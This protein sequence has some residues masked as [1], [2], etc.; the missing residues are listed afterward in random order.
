MTL[1]TPVSTPAMQ[2]GPFQPPPR[3]ARP[4]A[5]AGV[6]AAG[7]AAGAVSTPANQLQHNH[8]H[9]HN[10]SNS[11]GSSFHLDNGSPGRNAQPYSSLSDSTAIS[12]LSISAAS[13]SGL[14]GSLAGFS[15]FG[16]PI[17]PPG[18]QQQQQAQE[19]ARTT[20]M[21]T[22]V[23]PSG[24]IFR[25]PAQAAMFAGSQSE[26]SL[27]SASAGTGTGAESS[28]SASLSF[29]NRPGGRATAHAH[30]PWPGL[31]AP[32]SQARTHSIPMLSS[33][34]PALAQG[35]ASTTA[36]S[37]QST[38]QPDH[39]HSTGALVGSSSRTQLPHSQ[40]DVGDETQHSLY[41]AHSTS[42]DMMMMARHIQ[43]QQHPDSYD[44][45]DEHMEVEKENRAQMD[46]QRRQQ[47]QQQQSNARTR[48]LRLKAHIQLGL[49]I[50]IAKAPGLDPLVN[51]IPISNAHPTHARTQTGGKSGT[52]G[53]A[54]LLPL[55]LP[56]PAETAS[57][58]DRA[59]LA[60]RRTQTRETLVRSHVLLELDNIALEHDRQRLRLAI[61]EK[62]K[63][64]RAN[65]EEGRRRR[66]SLAGK[67]EV[68]VE[69]EVK[70]ECKKENESGNAMGVV[71][72]SSW[73]TVDGGARQEASG[74]PPRFGPSALTSNQ[75]NE[76][77]TLLRASPGP[78]GKAGGS[79]PH[80]N[81]VA[82]LNNENRHA[83]F[84]LQQQVANAEPFLSDW[85]YAPP[86]PGSYSST[87]SS[88]RRTRLT[89]APPLAKQHLQQHALDE[90]GDDGN[91][92]LSSSSSSPALLL[93]L[94][95]SNRSNGSGDGA[96]GGFF[97]ARQ[98]GAELGS[99]APAWD[100]GPCGRRLRTA[101]ELEEWGWW[102]AAGLE[103]VPGGNVT[104]LR[105]AGRTRWG[106]R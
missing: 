1:Q 75:R 47:Q 90:E 13:S 46:Q 43:R 37:Q 91:A 18:A 50:P 4:T 16:R 104:G 14:D 62:S 79:Q 35:V 5:A 92:D 88:A 71:P 40:H 28:F 45:I 86:A 52:Q 9:T 44:V 54:S 39:A 42:T 73:S 101:G 66:G 82:M 84:L 98:P 69:V 25:L 106:R 55:P 95:A 17:P 72:S 41:Q 103:S 65:R 29:P 31:L 76:L 80:R 21:H 100:V 67:E 36:S 105:S 60:Q 68:E 83:A 49:A 38:S 78:D 89:A 33:S 61:E 74:A 97:S 64:W 7:A 63:R 85:A 23:L 34:T 58:R 11:D 27:L 94:G 3:P 8:N 32:G 102:G 56:S 24:G 2:T 93:L 22:R 77:K 51:V 30:A 6:A 12:H 26:S 53:V 59:Y 20:T 10:H 48:D 99:F 81:A 19:T 70:G 15:L 57:L 87:T 96:D